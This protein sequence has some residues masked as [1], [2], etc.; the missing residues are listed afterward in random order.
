[1]QTSQQ[2]P[3]LKTSVVLVTF[4]TMLGMCGKVE[5]HCTSR[6]ACE[7]QARNDCDGPNY[8]EWRSFSQ[9]DSNGKTRVTF[10]YQCK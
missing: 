10:V 6:A 2:R 3:G 5:I 9:T 1:M 4:T 7:Q 8:V